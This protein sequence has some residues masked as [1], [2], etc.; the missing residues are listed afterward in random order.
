M[1]A[2]VMAGGFG[3]RLKPL[4]VNLPKPMVPIV[5]VPV[6]EHVLKLLKKH[7][8]EEVLV[9]LYFHPAC[10]THYFGDGSSLNMKIS[11][12]LPDSDLGT[13]GAV[14]YAVEK[15]SMEG[16]I[17]IIS[18][19]L[20][21]D[22]D[23]SEALEFHWKKNGKATIVLTSVKNPTSYGVV[24]T[25]EN[26]R[27]ERFL[28]KP[29]WGEVFSDTI[30]TGIYVIEREALSFIPKDREFDFSKH[31][32]PMLLE[33][34][35]PLYGYVAQGYWRDIG[36]IDDYR[37]GV[38]DV[39]EGKVNVDIPGERWEENR[40]WFGKGVEVNY[41]AK[42]EGSVAL[43]E[44]VKVGAKACIK[45][46]VIGKNTIVGKHTN[47]ENCIIWDNCAIG[48]RSSLYGDI[49]CNNVSIGDHVE[50]ESDVVI[51]DH[52]KIGSG[53]VIK[54]RVRIWPYKEVEARSILTTSLIW[55]KRWS[56][57]IFGKYGV[58]G[59]ANL[60]ISPEFASKLG[61]AFG[62]TFKERTTLV[63]SRD[64]HKASRAINR[65]LMAGALSSGVN[66]EDLSD[67]P[68]PVLRY[69]VRN[70]VKVGGF[71]VRRSPF[72]AEVVDI[73]FV[74]SD[75]IDI[76]V[77][78]EKQIERLFFR[79]DFRRANYEDV[80]NLSFPYHMIES[81]KNS[82]L[83][84]I[85]ADVIKKRALRIV[86]DYSFGTSVRILP[87]ILGTLGCDVI[88]LNA[89]LDPTKTTRT[90]EEFESA[91]ERIADIVKSTRSDMGVLLDAGGEKAFFIDDRGDI[92][93]GSMAL[94]IA[95]YLL[96]GKIKKAG[97][98]VDAPSSLESLCKD[99]EIIHFPLAMK[100]IM[101]YANRFNVDFAADTEGGFIFGEFMPTFDGMFTILKLLAMLS[102]EDAKLSELERM[103]PLT[104]QV[105]LTIP[106]SFE[107][108][109]N[110]MRRLIEYSRGKEAI[111]TCGVK[112]KVDNSW[113]L[114]Y[115]DE[116]RSLFHLIVEGEDKKEA[117]MRAEEWK[118]KIENW[119]EEAL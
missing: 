50:G 111:T 116:D 64:S 89:F 40:V 39:L 16:T 60:E 108:R 77:S 13:A 87:A 100:E 18:A 79:G 53:A 17:L 26:G 24:I 37:S 93:S 38:V 76:S 110:V 106:C 35:I 102:D 30:N 82:V 109:G 14:R 2:I 86:I 6:M 97:L 62:A 28:E 68:L 8:V 4:T 112:F 61:A 19:D 49:V 51:S 9:L 115:P 98:P 58:S 48:E 70:S 59:I 90:K 12:C 46:S 29:A 91:L 71:H 21:C 107:E 20:L 69:L 96:R 45:N 74:D 104:P 81:Y 84:H 32:F 44:N 117:E 47:I 88:S 94:G 56:R 67:M 11:Y 105:K 66:V 43:G 33:E 80:G 119:I 25:D 95:M 103:I 101:F 99:Y 41:T 65:A 78:K 27:V 5:N 54:E 73:K 114:V 92:L 52:C 36:S 113:I 7:S 85:E 10:I 23:L 57:T 83:Q 1:K 118:E 42:L 72:D 31:L 55:S 34:N 15:A 75:G 63:T 22:F 3:T